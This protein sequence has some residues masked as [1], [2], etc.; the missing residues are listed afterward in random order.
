MRKI[1]LIFI[2]LLCV[3]YLVNPGAGFIE[4]IPDQ[5]P[6]I[7]NIDEVTVTILLLKILKELGLNLFKDKKEI[8][9]QK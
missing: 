5:L 6:F 4:I 2:A 9:E 8:E 1:F 3:I 7:G